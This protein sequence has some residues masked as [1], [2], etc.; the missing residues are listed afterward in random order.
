MLNRYSDY[1]REMA[2]LHTM[3]E[4][5]VIKVIMGEPLSEFD[6]FVNEWYSLGGGHHRKC[7]IDGK[8]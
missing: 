4:E 7:V 8:K 5:M 3:E 2:A 6:A 1:V